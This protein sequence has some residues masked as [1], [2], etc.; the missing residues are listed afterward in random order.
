MR[1]ENAWNSECTYSHRAT[2]HFNFVA[3]HLTSGKSSYRY[4]KSCFFCKSKT[5]TSRNEFLTHACIIIVPVR[6]LHRSR[7]Y[8]RE[9]PEESI[10]S[11][12][13]VTWSRESAS[14]E[15]HR[16]EH[17]LWLWFHGGKGE[18]VCGRDWTDQVVALATMPVQSHRRPS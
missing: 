7:S 14:L 15:S 8:D 10:D 16:N 17:V 18:Y 6:Q 9:I 5:R 11:N 4:R 1:F 3:R 13:G 2:N 12:R